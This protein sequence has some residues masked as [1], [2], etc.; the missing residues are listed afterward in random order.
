M[1]RVSVVA[2]IVVLSQLGCGGEAATAN[3][4]ATASTPPEAAP[5][6]QAATPTLN[7]YVEFPASAVKIRQPVGF[8]TAESFDGFEQPETISS[9]LSTATPGPFAEF[10]AAF[11]R[12]QMEKRGWT[13]Q[14]REDVTVDGLPGVLVQFD[15]PLSGQV[16]AKWS[17]IF[18]SEQRSNMVTATFPKAHAAQLS[19]RLKASVLSA[20]PTGQAP[21]P[22]A[23]LPFIMGGSSKLQI[24]PS[25]SN[26][27]T[28]T[29]DGKIPIQ[30]PA[31]PL[32]IATQ[33]LGKVDIPNRREFSL[34]RLQQT[35]NISGL[36]VQSTSAITIDG[37][38]GFETLARARDTKTGTP[39]I[40][41]Q[42]I[43]FPEDSYFIIQGQ[44]GQALPGDFISEFK[45][46]ARSLKR[47]T[48]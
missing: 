11:T 38:S 41:Y 42:T 19:E 26:A 17:L 10:S 21:D 32:F 6:P 3:P 33:A 23:R 29:R 9:V 48:P 28:F 30:S 31:D 16:F 4:P 15:Q 22:A 13:L 46:L 45:A 36:T 47:R 25:I 40:V 44:V 39:L 37:L 34:Q 14:G 12:E 7:D 24:S 18:G 20:R 27:F 35:A 1:K 5:E 8:K 43:L 2:A